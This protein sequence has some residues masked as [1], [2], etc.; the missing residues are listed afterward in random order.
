MKSSGERKMQ[1]YQFEDANEISEVLDTKIEPLFSLPLD[2]MSPKKMHRTKGDR[3]ITQKGRV[4]KSYENFY[5]KKRL[6][7]AN[8][9]RYKE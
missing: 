2:L 9:R 1:K 3:T 4:S 7:E 8:F 5:T 6:S